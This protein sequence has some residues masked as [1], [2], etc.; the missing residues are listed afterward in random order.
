[1][2]PLV[3][4][5]AV[6]LDEAIVAQEAGCSRE[7]NIYCLVSISIFHSVAFAFFWASSVGGRGCVCVSCMAFFLGRTCT[8]FLANT[9]AL[10][11]CWIACSYVGCVSCVILN[12]I[13]I[14]FLSFAR[15]ASWPVPRSTIW[16]A[17]RLMFASVLALLRGLVSFALGMCADCYCTIRVDCQGRRTYCI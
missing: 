14:S 12:I 5:Q 15:P 1:M 6:F 8:E 16:Q 3:G 13:Y 17:L 9:S 11:L 7:D 10:C 4:R 2:P